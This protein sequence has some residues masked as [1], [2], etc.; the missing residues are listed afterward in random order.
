MIGSRLMSTKHTLT[1]VHVK[2]QP[3]ALTSISTE[4]FGIW[5]LPLALTSLPWLSYARPLHFNSQKLLV[6]AYE[7]VQQSTPP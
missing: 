6:F 5:V 2:R 7:V 1:I 4:S 3:F